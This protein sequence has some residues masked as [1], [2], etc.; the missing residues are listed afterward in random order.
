M[1]A[2]ITLQFEIPMPTFILRIKLDSA[3]GCCNKRKEHSS[4]SRAKLHDASKKRSERKQV[5]GKG[6]EGKD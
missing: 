3:S 1:L 6:K 2:G 5:V 4:K